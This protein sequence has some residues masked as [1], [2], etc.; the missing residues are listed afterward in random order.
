MRVKKRKEKKPIIEVEKWL[1]S[2]NEIL[3]SR[4]EKRHRHVYRGE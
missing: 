1:L 3:K 2:T 4:V